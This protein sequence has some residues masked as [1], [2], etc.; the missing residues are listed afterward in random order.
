MADFCRNYAVLCTYIHKTL[1]NSNSKNLLTKI[2]QYINS[3]DDTYRFDFP[4]Y[5]IVLYSQTPDKNSEFQANAKFVNNAFETLVLK[6][7]LK[8][9]REEKDFP[10]ILIQLLSIP[11]Y[12]NAISREV[13]LFVLF[14]DTTRQKELFD[15]KHSQSSYKQYLQMVKLLLAHKNNAL[16]C[17]QRLC[18]I[19]Q[20]TDNIQ[21]AFYERLIEDI[22]SLKTSPD[23]G[24]SEVYT[25]KNILHE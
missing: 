8:D 14:S 5:G 4:E 25:V 23:A 20:K 7:L 9:A 6:K 11:E 1:N 15:M 10:H 22:N 13:Y 17:V 24:L 16:H 12:E 3:H 19:T 21:K 18:A 2:E